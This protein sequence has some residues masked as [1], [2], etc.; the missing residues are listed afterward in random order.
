MEERK[1]LVVA[2]SDD[3]KSIQREKYNKALRNLVTGKTPKE[4]VFKKPGGG[5][6]TV[7]YVPGWWFVEQLNSLFGYFWDFEV[8]QEFVGQE[9]IW[10]RGKLTVKDPESGLTISK[11]AY[12]GSRIKSKNNP[13][14]DIGDDLKSAATDALKKAATLLGLAADIYGKREILEATAPSKSQLDA[15]Y[16]VGDKAN[17][18]IAQVDEFVNQKYPGKDFK[19]LEQI[20]I[21]G[22]IQDLR[23]RIPTG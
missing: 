12:G 6:A 9:Q 22:L 3:L 11:S 1:S 2:D 8:I 21:L 20:Q 4:V 15:L 5:G 10:V 7:D 14:I 23:K 18:T 19:E 17:L 16:K 13:A